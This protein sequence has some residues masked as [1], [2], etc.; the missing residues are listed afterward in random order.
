MQLYTWP[1]ASPSAELLCALAVCCNLLMHHCNFHWTHLALKGG[2]SFSHCDSLPRRKV[3]QLCLK[4]QWSD[5]LLPVVGHHFLGK[6]NVSMCQ[7]QRTV[8]PAPLE[9]R[10]SNWQWRWQLLSSD[11][12]FLI[13]R[14]LIDI[15]FLGRHR[16]VYVSLPTSRLIFLLLLSLSFLSGLLLHCYL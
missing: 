2:G 3:E 12:F 4:V 14:H 15:A 10:L 8:A 6:V 16:C 9:R 7:C 13:C 5:P 11:V 1:T